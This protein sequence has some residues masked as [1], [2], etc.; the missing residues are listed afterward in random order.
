MTAEDLGSLR[1]GRQ[2]RREMEKKRVFSLLQQQTPK[3]SPSH[4][5]SGADSLLQDSVEE[6]QQVVLKSRRRELGVKEDRGKAE[7]GRERQEEGR[8]LLL[9]SFLWTKTRN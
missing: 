5:S 2:N 3:S 8:V 1:E 7:R 4:P 9:M 6:K